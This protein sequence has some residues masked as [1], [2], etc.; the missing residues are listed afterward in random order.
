MSEYENERCPGPCCRGYTLLVKCSL[1]WALGISDFNSLKFLDG[2]IFHSELQNENELKCQVTGPKHVVVFIRVH[3]SLKN[4][5]LH[6]MCY[7]NQF[8]YES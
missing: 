1:V 7:G 4:R 8:Y 6:S 3:F 2:S 5:P